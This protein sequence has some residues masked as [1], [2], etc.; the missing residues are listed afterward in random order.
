MICERLGERYLRLVSFITNLY[1]DFL[2]LMIILY[3]IHHLTWH[4]SLNILKHITF[5]L[6]TE[7]MLACCTTFEKFRKVQL[8][9]K[10]THNST[11]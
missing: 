3:F 7:V 4:H 5:F 1:D 8:R 11:F 6:N 9:S 10:I 2:I